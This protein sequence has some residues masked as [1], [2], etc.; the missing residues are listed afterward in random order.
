M[1][2]H[3]GHRQSNRTGTAQSATAAAPAG[4]RQEGLGQ[5][6]PGAARARGEHGGLGGA[7]PHGP[8]ATS[9]LRSLAGHG[10][11]RRP[12]GFAGPGPRHACSPRCLAARCLR[13]LTCE[14]EAGCSPAGRGK[15]AR[16][17]A[18]AGT[19]RWQ[20]TISL[21]SQRRP[22][23]ST[24]GV[25]VAPVATA[26]S[27]WK[28]VPAHAAPTLRRPR[29]QGPDVH[30]GLTQEGDALHG[31]CRHRKPAPRISHEIP[32]PLMNGQNRGRPLA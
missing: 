12:A 11:W 21:A 23:A 32:D 9:R 24:P 30:P 5:R 8:E 19:G 15:W 16:V 13:P 6:G 3:K 17:T 7:G 4:T 29:G 1:K 31:L 28:A 27:A 25:S 14:A 18:A 20:G 26:L 10:L 2:H 22:V